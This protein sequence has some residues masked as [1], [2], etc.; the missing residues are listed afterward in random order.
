MKAR[1][2]F[3]VDFKGNQ[4]VQRMAH[5]IFLIRWPLYRQKLEH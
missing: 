1:E 3:D 2:S 5:V 4:D